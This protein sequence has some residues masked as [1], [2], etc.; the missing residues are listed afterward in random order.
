MRF[1]SASGTAVAERPAPTPR[2]DPSIRV[3]PFCFD[4]SVTVDVPLVPWPRASA[5]RAELARRDAPC[6]LVVGADAPAPAQ[7]TELEDWVRDPVSR[8]ELLTRATT[9]ARR[10]DLCTRPVLDRFRCVTFRGRTITVPATYVP[11]VAILIEGFGDVVADDEILALCG[12]HGASTHAEAMK[13]TLRRIK[14]SLAPLGLRL[15]RVRRAGY[16]LDRM[17]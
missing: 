9:V 7:W 10:A 8:A 17:A 11:L 1:S 14:D 3:H 15:S 13:T 12:E 6:L 16:L 5:R 4:P 2:L